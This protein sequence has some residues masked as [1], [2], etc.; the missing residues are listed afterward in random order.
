M[1]SSTSCREKASQK[2]TQ[3]N[4]FKEPEPSTI[5]FKYASKGLGAENDCNTSFMIDTTFRF[6]L[7]PNESRVLAR[8]KDW[9]PPI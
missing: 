8:E 2:A 4:K 6:S 9:K 1:Q 7:N 5:P 3:R